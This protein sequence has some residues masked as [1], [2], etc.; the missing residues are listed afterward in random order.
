MTLSLGLD[1][2]TTN[3]VIAMP[4]PTGGAAAAVFHHDNQAVSAFRSVLCFW[5]EETRPQAPIMAE[6]GPWAIAHFL[7][8]TGH[9][10]FL[11]SLK[12][13]A[14]SQ[15]FQETR[16]Y[17]R[18][19]TF[20]DLLETFLKLMRGHAGAAI[21]PLPR[22][23]VAGRPVR[24]AGSN[25]D[26]Q[27]ALGRYRQALQRFGA[28]EVRFV[29]EP[30]AA[31]FFFAQRLTGDATVLVADFGGGTSDFSIMRF[32]LRNGRMH[33]RALAWS[34]VGVAG[35]TFDYH[36]VDKLISP[37]LGKGTRYMSMGKELELPHRFFVSFARWSE[38][39]VMKTSRDFRDLKQLLRQSL[40]PKRLQWLI[41]VIEMDLGY[42]LY[43]AVSEAKMRLSVM[44]ETDFAFEAETVVLRD[45]LR[46]PV[47]EMWIAEDLKRIGGA[48]DEAMHRA[49]LQ[50]AAIDKVFLTG[51]SSFVPAVR[52]MFVDRFG[53]G[54]IES[55]DELTSIA[56][57]LALIGE[58]DDIDQW[59]AP[60]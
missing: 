6:A 18:R 5:K 41:D 15:L 7:E 37:R 50:P 39:S 11:Q 19:F 14:A 33:P 49:Q 17:G 21:E 20:E 57:G 59:C 38:L 9:C 56:H 43:K 53:A 30:V 36:I 58:R 8:N 29:F 44:K 1:F 60:D 4:S 2:G 13:Y 32:E 54:K 45:T 10:R 28:E 23:F 25:P 42:A 16:I 26:A 3:T 31:A 48:V 24:F 47:F 35:D 40:E 22:R 34:G 46:R 27:L 55:G 51:G 52:R 12:S